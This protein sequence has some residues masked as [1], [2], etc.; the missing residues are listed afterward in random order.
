MKARKAALLAGVGRAVDGRHQ[1]LPG[2]HRRQ[3]DRGQGGAR[4]GV[5]AE[6][7]K[8]R[9]SRGCDHE[10]IEMRKGAADQR[11]RRV[12]RQ[13]AEQERG[14]AEREQRHAAEQQRGDDQ[15]GGVDHGEGSERI[16]QRG[17][18]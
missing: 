12:G 6:R 13:R 16:G 11:S 5:D 14:E 9:G 17:S 3:R 15:G 4:K 2:E 10:Q 1:D 7:E 8:A 18:M